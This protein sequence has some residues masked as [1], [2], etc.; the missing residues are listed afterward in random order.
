MID[1]MIETAKAQYYEEQLNKSHYFTKEDV[2]SYMK[3]TNRESAYWLLLL[4]GPDGFENYKEYEELENFLK[5]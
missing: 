2:L 4:V 5:N 3:E 1:T